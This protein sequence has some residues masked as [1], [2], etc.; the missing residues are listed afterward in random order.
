MKNFKMSDV[1]LVLLRA[2][3]REQGKKTLEHMVNQELIDLATAQAA[4]SEAFGELLVA[5]PEE[6]EDELAIMKAVGRGRVRKTLEGMINRGL[7][8]LAMAQ[9]VWGDA[10]GGSL[11]AVPARTIEVNL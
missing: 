8:T 3:G 6:A 4:W 10:F 5:V 9:S 7:I 1:D 11:I 2:M